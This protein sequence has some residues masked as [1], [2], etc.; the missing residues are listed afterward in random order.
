MSCKLGSNLPVTRQIQ[1]EPRKEWAST[2]LSVLYPGFQGLGFTL[3][4]QVPTYHIL[5]KIVSVSLLHNCYLKPEYLNIGPSGPL[6]LELRVWAL[7]PKP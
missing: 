3:R 4:V 1:A 5:S 2:D 6:G 7:S